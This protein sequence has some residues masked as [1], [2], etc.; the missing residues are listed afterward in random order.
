MSRPPSRYSVA[1]LT[2]SPLVELLMFGV[3]GGLRWLGESDVE[4]RMLELVEGE[5]G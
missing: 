1:C 3:R 4:R 2:S 5:R